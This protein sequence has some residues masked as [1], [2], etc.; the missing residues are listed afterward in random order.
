M[1]LNRE[2]LAGLTAIGWRGCPWWD[3]PAARRAFQAGMHG[4]SWPV[5]CRQGDLNE[6]AKLVGSWRRV[7][8]RGCALPLAGILGGT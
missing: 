8:V 3:P 7:V 6:Y 1:S 4:L 2:K 5:S